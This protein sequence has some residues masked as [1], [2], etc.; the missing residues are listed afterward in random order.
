[1]ERSN[2]LA[3][4]QL[5]YLKSIADNTKRTADSNDKIKEAVEETRDMI[6]GAR[7]DK[8]RGLYVR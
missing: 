6:H 5:T 3:E 8:S 2:I 1:M 4:S 7:T